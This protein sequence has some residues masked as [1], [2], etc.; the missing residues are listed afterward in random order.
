LIS[1]SSFSVLE[2]VREENGHPMKP[3][4]RGLQSVASPDKELNRIDQMRN[5]KFG[6]TGPEIDSR[7][8]KVLGKRLLLVK[9]HPSVTEP[10]G[11]MTRQGKLEYPIR[12]G[13]IKTWQPYAQ[14]VA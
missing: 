5:G 3:L 2:R 13:R 14:R 7:S 1:A 4:T 8:I 6:L 10:V 11:V 12:Q 9:V